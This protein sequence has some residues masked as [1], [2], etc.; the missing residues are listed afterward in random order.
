[1]L[2]QDSKGV[3]YQREHRFRS[4]PFTVKVGVHRNT[5]FDLIGFFLGESE[6]N[7]TDQLSS[8]AERNGQRQPGSGAEGFNGNEWLKKQPGFFCGASFVSGPLRY[9][10]ERTIGV[11]G[12]SV[13]ESYSSEDNAVSLDVFEMHSWHQTYEN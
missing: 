11:D 12:V 1:M 7:I 4:V 2:S 13:F 10:R 5:D 9:V 8:L 3:A 6:S